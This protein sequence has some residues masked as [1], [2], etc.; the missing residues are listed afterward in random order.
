MNRNFLLLLVFYNA[1]FGAETRSQ[2][3]E[4]CRTILPKL[5]PQNDET[6]LRHRGD[7]KEGGFCGPACIL[8]AAVAMLEVDG[9]SLS[10]AEVKKEI[11]LLLTVPN[12]S[13]YSGTNMDQREAL[14]KAYFARKGYDIVTEKM[15]R[16][17]FSPEDLSKLSDPNERG[18]FAVGSVSPYPMGFSGFP[19]PSHAILITAYDPLAKEI[20]YID[21]MHPKQEK[22]APY[23]IQLENKDFEG[24][25]KEVVFLD[26]PELHW[27]ND[28]VLSPTST[29]KKELYLIQAETYRLKKMQKRPGEPRG[30]KF[31]V[32][33][34]DFR[35]RV[36]K[37]LVKEKSL[38]DEELKVLMQSFDQLILN[39]SEFNSDP[40]KVTLG[41]YAMR[42]SGKYDAQ[43]K[44][45]DPLLRFLNEMVRER[46]II[47]K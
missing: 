12:G 29:R 42:K 30:S 15:P 20:F 31:T 14:A 26:A 2:L 37:F 6:Y 44:T 22:K 9:K 27:I 36:L 19:P 4:K 39:T 32:T 16:D 40:L 11:E 3:Q 1:L 45:L 33:P 46:V 5:V 7:V 18:F 10:E 41:L 23:R 24:N 43:S 34:E 21:P 13:V 28:E 38:S 35:Q 25:K 47:E 17:S 8:N